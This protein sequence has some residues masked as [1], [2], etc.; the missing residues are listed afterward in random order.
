MAQRLSR[1]EFIDRT[2]RIALATPFLSLVGCSQ[3]GVAGGLAL[4]GKTMGTTYSISLAALPQGLQ[5][6][7]LAAEIDGILDGVNRRMSTYRSD[8]ELS[9]FN[10]AAAG[11]SV[12]I[13]VAGRRA[14]ATAWRRMSSS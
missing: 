14:R 10:A 8:S 3:E 4:N 11:T 13:S 2:Q 12:P 1:R 7:A 9:Q 6:D 5:Q